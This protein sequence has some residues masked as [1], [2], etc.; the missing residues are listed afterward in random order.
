MQKPPEIKPLP[1]TEVRPLWSVMIPTYN[2]SSLLIEAIESVLI[3]DPGQDKMQIEVVDDAST[4]ADVRQ[5]VMNIGKGRVAYYRQS[6]NVGSLKN[7]ETC[8]NRAKGH[9]VHLLHADDKVRLGYYV[10][11]NSLFEQYPQIGAAFSC[12]DQI[13]ETE[14]IVPGPV[15][16]Q[17]K[18]GVLENWLIKIAERQRLQYCTISVKREVYE[19]IGG[20]Y[21]VS[22]GE[23][24]E[25]WARIA[26]HYDVAYTPERLALYR[27]HQNSI[28]FNALKTARNVRDMQW[29]IDTI[30]LLL[31]EKEKARV[32]KVASR[33]YATYSIAMA[34]NIWRQTK[35]RK[36]TMLQIREALRMYTDISMF[37]RIARICAR[38]VINK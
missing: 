3:Q 24:W 27:I 34:E 36:I 2:C 29:V 25:M 18:E 14:E 13:I 35:N 38:M 33:H 9:L 32:K 4:D 11:M 16:E 1:G 22:Y 20:Y 5:L 6:E 19:K 17:L 28:S 37:P 30:Q 23:D 15:P 12:Y 31:P 26:A 10:K 8:L 7:F 21:G